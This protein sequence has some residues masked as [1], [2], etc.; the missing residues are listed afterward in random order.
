MRMGMFE[1]IAF[2]DCCCAYDRE[3]FMESYKLWYKLHME[4]KLSNGGLI[5]T[6]S[7]EVKQYVSYSQR[8]WNESAAKVKVIDKALASGKSH[9]QAAIAAGYK[10]WDAARKFY[11]KYKKKVAGA[12]RG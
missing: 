7:G 8:R 10:N 12:D 6:D 4:A 9:N 3:S 5:S 1:Q 2:Q 11:R